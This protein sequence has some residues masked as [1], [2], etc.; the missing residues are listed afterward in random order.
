MYACV[1]K[2]HRCTHVN[3]S[4]TWNGSNV[5]KV[6][7]LRDIQQKQHLGE[8]TEDPSDRERHPTKVAER[9][10]DKALRRIPVVVEK[11]RGDTNKR[12]HQMNRQLVVGKVVRPR[13]NLQIDTVTS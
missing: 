12:Q 3:H 6:D 4:K 7:D 2:N 1:K 8:V 10:T 9:V 11:R 13:H 5:H